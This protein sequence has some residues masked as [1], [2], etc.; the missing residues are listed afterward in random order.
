MAPHVATRCFNC[1]ETRV[2]PIRGLRQ[3]LESRIQTGSPR[4]G[5]TS[6]SDRGGSRLATTGCSVRGT[7]V[8]A[9]I[10]RGQLPF[11][12]LSAAWQPVCLFEPAAQ[13]SPTWVGR[14]RRDDAGLRTQGQALLPDYPC[15][16]ETPVIIR[17]RRRQRAGP[18]RCGGR[19]SRRCRTGATGARGRRRRSRRDRPTLQPEPEGDPPRATVREVKTRFYPWGGVRCWMARIFTERLPANTA[20]RNWNNPRA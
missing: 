11:P 7:T 13:T 15:A 17:A 5:T 8:T 12:P 16:G 19:D 1:S 10:C 20:M 6:R 3:G 2:T 18:R 14:C 4:V 9:F